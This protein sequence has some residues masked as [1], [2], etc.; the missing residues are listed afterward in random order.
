MPG[1]KTIGTAAADPEFG[2]GTIRRNQIGIGLVIPPLISGTVDARIR[3]NEDPRLDLP[4][5]GD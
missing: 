3:S 5:D 1:L 4:F 2:V